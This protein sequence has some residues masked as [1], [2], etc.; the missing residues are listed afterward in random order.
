M[1]VSRNTIELSWQSKKFLTFYTYNKCQQ[2]ILAHPH[3]WQ[4]KKLEKL[5]FSWTYH[6]CIYPPPP[7]ITQSELVVS[8]DYEFND[9]K[10]SWCLSQSYNGFIISFYIHGLLWNELLR[11]MF[12]EGVIG[13]AIV[14][15]T[16]LCFWRQAQYCKW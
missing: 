12:G 9:W 13:I 5:D 7:P 14:F 4:T 3:G 2:R 6:S 1:T 15:S 8:P 16:A 11:W 10:S